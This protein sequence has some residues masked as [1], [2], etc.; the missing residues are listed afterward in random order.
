FSPDGRSV[1]FSRTFTLGVSEV[2]L[3]ELSEDLS[4]KEPPKQLTS[5]KQWTMGLT[6]TADGREIVY[7]SGAGM[8][9]GGVELRRGARTGAGASVGGGGP[10]PMADNFPPRRQAC[11][12]SKLCE[13]PEYLAVGSLR[14]EG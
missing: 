11:I 7:A 6:W 4:P 5:G 3:M 9:E 10:R 1:A 2:F 13:R 8:P 14:T 12:H